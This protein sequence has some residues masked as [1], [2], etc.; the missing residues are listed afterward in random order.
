MGSV[1]AGALLQPLGLCMG[2][3]G[4]SQGVTVQ[5]LLKP[6]PH[7]RRTYGPGIVSHSSLP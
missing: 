5:G 1:W 7:G 2:M 4:H 6:E 3:E